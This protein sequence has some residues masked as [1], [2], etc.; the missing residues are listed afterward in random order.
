MKKTI[1]LEFPE[2]FK[3]PRISLSSSTCWK[4]PVYCRG[5]CILTWCTED[6][7]DGYK[8][9]CPFYEEDEDE[10]EQM[11]LELCP[12]CG[13][14]VRIIVCDDEGNHRPDGYE[15]KPWSGLGFMLYH[16]E[17]ENP[18]CPIAHDGESQL[19]RTIYD[20]KEE[21]ANAWNTRFE[22]KEPDLPWP[23]STFKAMG[24]VARE[25]LSETRTDRTGEK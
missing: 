17:E 23:Y 18:N 21:A 12:F 4:C 16:S 5:I 8:K 22:P 20:S 6:M 24:D 10:V 3:F 25:V 15:E 13:G 9:A 11:E 7:L 1:A 19:G 14:V 2:G